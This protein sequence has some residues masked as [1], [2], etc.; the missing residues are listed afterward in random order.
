VCYGVVIAPDASSDEDCSSIM[1]SCDRPLFCSRSPHAPASSLLGYLH[2]LC[3]SLEVSLPTES[4]SERHPQHLQDQAPSLGLIQIRTGHYLGF[5][6]SDLIGGNNGWLSLVRRLLRLV[7][8]ENDRPVVFP[9]LDLT[10][11]PG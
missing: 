1:P 3:T 4:F 11:A 7:I 2:E 8:G 5:R 6:V 9:D 10:G